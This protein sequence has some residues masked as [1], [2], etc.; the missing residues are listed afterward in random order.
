MDHLQS[1]VDPSYPPLEILDL[2]FSYTDDTCIHA[3]SGLCTNCHDE[4]LGNWFG[5]P[6]RMGWDTASILQCRLRKA[7]SEQNQLEEAPAFLQAW[8]YF[9]V[10]AFFFNDVNV[11][12]NF[13]RRKDNGI[14]ILDTSSLPVHL[15]RWRHGIEAMSTEERTVA[16]KRLDR[17]FGQLDNLCAMYLA[18]EA[19]IEGFRCPVSPELSLSIQILGESLYHAV[20]MVGA[21]SPY[22]FGIGNTP[23]LTQRLKAN[24]WCPK[25]IENIGRICLVYY[26]SL[27]GPRYPQMSHDDCTTE[28]CRNW[29]LMKH[30]M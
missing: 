12:L 17:A 14:R 22:M 23:L 13:L 7:D 21:R 1:P 18:G 8:L 19:V 15:L 10:L 24:F 29:M 30:A 27:M 5:F 11:I 28:R 3:T 4:G 2:G 25:D 20:Y 6:D 26:A 9:G 16:L